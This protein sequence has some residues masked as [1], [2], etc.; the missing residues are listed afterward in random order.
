MDKVRVA[1]IG[2]GSL[3]NRRHYPSVTSLPDVEVAAIAELNQERAHATADK[4]GVER[5]YADYRKMLDEVDPHAVYVIMPPQYLYDLVVTI[6]KQKRAV[7]I[8]KPPGMTTLQAREFAY[9]AEE[10]GCV[11]Q[12]GFQR[13]FIPAM[14]DLKRRVEQRGPIHSVSVAFLKATNNLK[15][16][17]G[18]Y[19]GVIDPLTVDGIH[20]VDNLRWLGGGEVV[21]VSSHVRAR[22]VPGPVANAVMAQVEFA[23]GAVGQLHFSYVTGQRIFRAEIHGQNATAYVDADRE[24]YFVADNGEPEVIQSKQYGDAL[25]GQEEHWLGFWHEAR[26]FIDSVK[27]GRVD[28]DGPT[29]AEGAKTMEL[30]DRIYQNR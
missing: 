26:H 16:P 1:F 30:V 28:H 17:A 12:V 20:A 18:V 24:S 27:E 23:S 3:A 8:E 7:F 19:G 10:N 5:V 14:T 15:Q 9:F 22:Y 13:R 29:F 2:A 25:G 21:R 6:L 4:F 11:T